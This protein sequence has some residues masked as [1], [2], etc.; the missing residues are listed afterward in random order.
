MISVTEI[1]KL[2]LTD[3]ISRLI[4]TCFKN[5]VERY[6]LNVKR[7]RADFRQHD[8]ESSFQGPSGPRVRVPKTE[9]TPGG[10]TN[11]SRRWHRQPNGS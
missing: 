7:G 10:A 5:Q 1:L 2:P 11:R 4:V 6:M 8:R 9:V 3:L